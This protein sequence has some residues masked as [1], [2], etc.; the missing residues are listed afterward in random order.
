MKKSHINAAP[1]TRQD[2]DKKIIFDNPIR[3]KIF[4]LFL[5]GKHYSVTDLS[6]LLSI[7]DPRSH[8]RYIRD[9]GYPVSDYWIKTKF[10]KYKVYFLH[11]EKGRTNGN[12]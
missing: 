10:S 11:I 6:K 7:P 9:A 8:I 5:T 2:K 3:T 4:N 1:H 12:S